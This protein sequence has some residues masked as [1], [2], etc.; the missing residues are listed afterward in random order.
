MSAPEALLCAWSPHN[1]RATR[2][3]IDNQIAAPNVATN[4]L[5][6]LMRWSARIT[7]CIGHEQNKIVRQVL[8]QDASFVVTLS[9]HG[10][11]QREECPTP[12]P[13]TPTTLNESDSTKGEAR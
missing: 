5:A 1:L 13:A 8:I 4:A 11:T 12:M 3:A 6:Y 10:G 2:T 7:L 9:V